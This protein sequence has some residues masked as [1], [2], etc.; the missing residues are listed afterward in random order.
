[1]IIQFGKGFTHDGFWRIFTNS[2]WGMFWILLMLPLITA[3]GAW[4]Y[5]NKKQ[6]FVQ[7]PIHAMKHTRNMI[8]THWENYWEKVPARKWGY[9]GWVGFP[10]FIA[11]ITGIWLVI[12]LAIAVILLCI[13]YIPM[14]GLPSG[15]EQAK[16]EVLAPLSCI[17]QPVKREQ[18]PDRQ[19]H[20]LR[21]M[22]DG[23]ELARGRLIEY[24]ADRVFLYQ[25]STKHWL[26]VPLSNAIVEE[27][28][29]LDIP[30]SVNISSSTK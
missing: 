29:S 4:G 2:W 10:G 20:C 11:I 17:G 24:G 12:S 9:G 15:R 14:W 3:I 25:P 16:N 1:V 6:R 8:V 18:D 7:M 28:D 30:K 27:V 21:V 22:R 19:S 13:A 26:S 5:T 23:K